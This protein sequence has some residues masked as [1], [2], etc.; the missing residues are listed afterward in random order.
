MTGKKNVCSHLCNWQMYLPCKTT[1]S[2]RTTTGSS[3][4]H[5][6]IGSRNRKDSHHVVNVIATGEEV[7]RLL[8]ILGSLL[9][10]VLKDTCVCSSLFVCCKILVF[11]TLGFNMALQTTRALVQSPR[12]LCDSLKHQ[13]AHTIHWRCCRQTPANALSENLRL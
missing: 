7:A 1:H 4:D 6:F 10:F 9:C 13:C 5:Y 11:A 2:N 8:S 3:R 12:E